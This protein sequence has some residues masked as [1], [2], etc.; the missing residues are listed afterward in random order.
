[1]ARDKVQRILDSPQTN[2]DC[3]YQLCLTQLLQF[4]RDAFLNEAMVR[5]CFKNVLR[6]TIKAQLSTIHTATNVKSAELALTF[7]RCVQDIMAE[8]Y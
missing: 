6:N 3:D 5:E 8:S 1:M 2:D 7:E 4:P